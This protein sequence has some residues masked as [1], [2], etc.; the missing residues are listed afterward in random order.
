M[1]KRSQVKDHSSCNMV[2]T[3][4]NRDAG[5]GYSDEEMETGQDATGVVIQGDVNSHLHWDV[6]LFPPLKDCLWVYLSRVQD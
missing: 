6:V 2:S 1:I 3:V 4:Y 5:M